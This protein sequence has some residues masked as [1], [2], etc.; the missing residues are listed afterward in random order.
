MV[1]LVA[2]GTAVLLVRDLIPPGPENALASEPGAFIQAGSRQFVQWRPMRRESIQEARRLDRPIFLCIGTGWSRVGRDADTK[3]F[4]EQD[5]IERINQRFLP[6][7]VDANLHPRWLSAYLPVSRAEEPFDVGFQLYVLT[8]DGKLVD[9]MLRRSDRA[10]FDGENVLAFLRRA[11]SFLARGGNPQLY[12]LQVQEVAKLREPGPSTALNFKERMDFLVQVQSASNG[13]YSA[14]GLMKVQPEAWRLLWLGNRAEAAKPGVDAVLTSPIIDWIRGGIRRMALESDW[15][16]VE[17]D[18]VTLLSADVM[19]A[20]AEAG[21]RYRDPLFTKASKV[22][23]DGLLARKGSGGSFSAY[24]PGDER[25]NRRS[26]SESWSPSRMR[27]HFSAEER[28]DLR[29][30][31]GL[32]V[33]TNPQMLVRV[34]DP[35]AWKVEASLVDRLLARLRMVVDE[36]AQPGVES[37]IAQV[38]GYVAARMMETARLLGDPE[39]I[40][41]VATLYERLSVYRVGKDDLRR[42]IGAT[43]AERPVLVDYLAYADAAMEEYLLF[44]RE[45]ALLDGAATLKRALEFFRSNDSAA[46]VHA[47]SPDWLLPLDV[48]SPQIV[49]DIVASS[50]AQAI[51]LCWKYGKLLGEPFSRFAS[52]SVDHFNSVVARMRFD[53]AGY[54]VS[55]GM[56]ANDRMVA[57]VGANAIA[58]ARSLSRDAPGWFIAPILGDLRPDLRA[59]TSGLWLIGPKDT[60]GPLNLTDAVRIVGQIR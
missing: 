47:I 34:A 56:V 60:I 4:T 27:A 5:V 36:V 40:A 46:L 1:V 21:L 49:D 33:E 25:I 53:V 38:D 14:P 42:R 41:S 44:G 19:T 48:S 55:A 35:K 7:R 39:R 37:G 11:E 13:A 29:R 52:N 17:L 59:K 30:L 3:A 51:R 6:I 15:S 57:A 58:E 24:M 43:A 16:K 9:R 32:H 12:N 50:S 22:V 28:A 8:P 2:I 23:F 54:Y 31:M 20:L 10:R 26:A 18:Q 45:D